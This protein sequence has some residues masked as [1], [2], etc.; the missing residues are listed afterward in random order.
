MELTVRW[1]TGTLIVAVTTAVLAAGLGTPETPTP[2]SARDATAPPAD[3]GRDLA[4]ATS[5][6]A[7]LEVH[8]RLVRGRRY[9]RWRFGAVGYDAD[10]NACDTRDDALR[11]DLRGAVLAADGCG[12]VGGT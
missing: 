11:R 10:G 2:P 3:G 7:G 4:L 8:A 1:S 5:G 9:A 12:V 6:L